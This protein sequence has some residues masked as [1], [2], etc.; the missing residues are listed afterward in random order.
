MCA[1]VYCSRIRDFEDGQ[2][3]VVLHIDVADSLLHRQFAPVRPP[4]LAPMT[5]KTPESTSQPTEQY[6]E[7]WVIREQVEHVTLATQQ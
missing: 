1:A 7:Y 4:P 2:V 6:F 5:G 3:E